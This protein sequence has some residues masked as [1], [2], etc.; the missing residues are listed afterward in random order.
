MEPIKIAPAKEILVEVAGEVYKMCFDF[1]AIRAFERESG[2]S[3]LQNT[4]W[5]TQLD[6]TS[7]GY[8]VWSMLLRTNPKFTIEQVCAM[9]SIESMLDIQK[10]CLAMWKMAMPDP[11][12]ERPTETS[13]ENPEPAVAVSL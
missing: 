10:V 4:T 2:K 5:T 13:T 9:F 11:A 12:E 1:N 3:V 7:L 8:L 6:G